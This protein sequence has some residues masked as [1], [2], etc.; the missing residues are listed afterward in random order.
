[1]IRYYLNY[2]FLLL[3]PFALGNG[4]LDLAYNQVLADAFS[5]AGQASDHDPLDWYFAGRCI[6]FMASET[7]LFFILNLAIEYKWFRRLQRL[8]ILYKSIS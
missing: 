3:P 7:L 5:A 4:L 8:A 2:V 6:F 1:M